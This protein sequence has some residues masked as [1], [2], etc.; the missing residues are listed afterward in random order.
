MCETSPKGEHGSRI[1]KSDTRGRVM[2]TPLQREELLRQ[3]ERSGL[4]GPRF[5]AAAGVKYQT[6]AS[7]LQRKKRAS[8]PLEEE[9]SVPQQAPGPEA[10]PSLQW[11]EAVLETKAAPV[12]ALS[13]QGKLRVELPG[14]AVALLSDSHQ[15]ALVV[16]L[17]QA[18]Q[19][20]ASSNQH[21]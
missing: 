16:E 13:S 9:T 10:M 20:K 1:L 12:P 21:A 15:I 7:W 19:G 3:Y 5:A 4:S 11:M 14:G 6:F 17:I 8:A 18:L 2:S